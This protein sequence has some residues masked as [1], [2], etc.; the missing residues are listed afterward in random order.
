MVLTYCWWQVA[1][2][3]SQW[4]AFR[5]M[6]KGIPWKTPCIWRCWRQGAGL[7]SVELSDN[8]VPCVFPGHHPLAGTRK[9]ANCACERALLTRVRACSRVPR[10]GTCDM[11]L[12]TEQA[13]VSAYHVPGKHWSGSGETFSVPRST[14]AQMDSDTDCTRPGVTAGLDNTVSI[15][16]QNSC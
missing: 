9:Q 11:C 3:I 12:F 5:W 2:Y 8:F 7:H 10:M 14:W 1:G 4:V 15:V 6:G 13:R 16:S